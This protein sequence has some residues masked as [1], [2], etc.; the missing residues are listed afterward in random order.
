[1]EQDESVTQILKDIRRAIEQ[2]SSNVA[3]T[4]EILARFYVDS[5]FDRLDR[6]RAALQA[7]VR[8][9]RTDH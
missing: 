5:A 1:M 2:L 7:L 6:E 4:N 9:L 3:F 8:E